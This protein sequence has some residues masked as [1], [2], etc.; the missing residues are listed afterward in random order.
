MKK[1]WLSTL[2]LLICLTVAGQPINDKPHLTITSFNDNWGG[3]FTAIHDHMRSLGFQADYQFKIVNQLTQARLTYSVMNNRLAGENASRMDEL[4]L[5]FRHPVWKPDTNLTVNA[6]AG[7][8]IAGNLQGEQIQNLVHRIVGVSEVHLPYKTQDRVFGFLGT[9]LWWIKP[10][11]EVDKQTQLNFELQ[12]EYQW[13]PG[14]LSAAMGHMGISLSNQYSD[15]ITL[16]LGYKQ[17]DVL[18]DKPVLKAVGSHETGLSV[19]YAMRLGVANFGMNI[20]P[21]N[22]FSSGYMGLSLLNWKDRK[23]LEQVNVI[24]EFG[25]LTGANGFYN[26]YLWNVLTEIDRFQLDLHYQFW[27]L[28]KDVFTA[29]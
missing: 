16:A 14:Y 15:K 9:A 26:R 27:T 17:R 5:Y 13:A 24:T 29:Y 10:M 4:E 25:S 8:Y 11:L 19:M 18:F 23:N 1:L 12:G 7:G 21:G 22:D 2:T 28:T 6:L 20:F 3:G